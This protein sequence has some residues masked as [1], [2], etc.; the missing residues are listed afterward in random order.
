M[1]E[2]GVDDNSGIELGLN[3]IVDAVSV[4]KTF[5]LIS[6]LGVA[7]IAAAISFMMPRY[8]MASTIILSPQNAQNSTGTALAQLGMLAG[9]VGGAMKSPDDLYVSLLRTRAIQDRIVKQFDLV[10]RYEQPTLSAARERLTGLTHIGADKK[11]GIINVDVED[12]EPGTAEA[13]ANAHVAELAELLKHIAVTEAQQR[14]MFYESQVLKAREALQAAE[15]KFQDERSHTG[16]RSGQVLAEAAAKASIELRAQLIAKEVQ[17]ASIR[18]Y[19]TPRNDELRRIQQEVSALR[20][21]LASIEMGEPS[22]KETNLAPAPAV[23]AYRD[24]KIQEAVLL[25]LNKQLEMARLTEASEGPL[26]QQIDKAVATE[27]PVRPRRVLLTV[28]GGLFGLSLAFCLVVGRRWRTL[29]RN[30]ED[31]S[32]HR[33]GA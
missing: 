32:L 20:S 19:A 11:T 7:L 28:G 6:A 3:D 29:A 12:T 23:Q 24:L 8:Y 18:S 33:R 31:G 30:S 21:Q 16:F 5:I 1:L 13:I 17:L 4:A 2:E 14:R 9:A 25:E 15:M 22:L 10:K 27:Y 26:L